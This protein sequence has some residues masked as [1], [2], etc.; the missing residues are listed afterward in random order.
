METKPET[1]SFSQRNVNEREVPSSAK[2]DWYCSSCS[3]QL[4]LSMHVSYSAASLQHKQL[5]IT[6]QCAHLKMISSS[7]ISKLCN[8]DLMWSSQTTI[9]VYTTIMV[10]V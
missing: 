2:Y 5:S 4:I 8:S 7:R 6:V 3:A 10:R 1:E 9:N